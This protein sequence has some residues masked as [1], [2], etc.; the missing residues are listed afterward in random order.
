M[1]SLPDG[2]LISG[3]GKKEKKSVTLCISSRILQSCRG[4]IHAMLPF[5]L[6]NRSHCWFPRAY[7]PH[8]SQ[9]LFLEHITSIHKICQFFPAVRRK[10]P[11]F[12]PTSLAVLHYPAFSCSSN[13]NS[14]IL[15]LHSSYSDF[16]PVSQL[17]QDF[18]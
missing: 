1:R 5:T 7:S 3:S 9:M 11:R 14:Y 2:L 17:F 4:M 18:S 10:I 6:S 12:F 8:C 16:P 15:L 13:L